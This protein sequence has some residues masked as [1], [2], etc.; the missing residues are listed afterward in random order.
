M[1][2]G[3]V[4]DRRR[5]G[6]HESRWVAGGPRARACQWAP[7]IAA[8]VEKEI[9]PD[10]RVIRVDCRIVTPRSA[11]VTVAAMRFYQ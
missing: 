2:P 1:M 8:S 11:T 3:A 5:D 4:S 7:V 9:S 6:G 10:I